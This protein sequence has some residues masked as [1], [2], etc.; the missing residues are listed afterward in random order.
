[1]I[2]ISKLVS[3]L[4]P[5]GIR[6]FFDLALGMRDVISLGV[7]EPDFPTPW[8]IRE[9]AIHYIEQG[10]TQYTSNKGLRELRLAITNRLRHEYELDYDPDN[11]ILIT[12]GVSEAFDLAIRTIINPGDEVIIP[13]PCY[14]A[15]GPVVTLAGGKP[16]F[17]PT[18]FNT[19][20]KLTPNEI[21]KSCTKKTKVIILGY[22]SNPTG[23]SY[24]K[25]EL[26]KL[27]MAIQKNNLIVISDELYSELTY[28]FKHTPW[29]TLKGAK[30]HCVYLNGFSKA[31]AMTGW[32]IGYAMGPKEIIDGMTKIHQYTMLSAPTM[33]QFA[34]LEA[35]QK[36][37]D[38]VIEMREEY[39]RRRNFVV[40]NLNQ[41]GLK[42]N[43]PQGAFYIFC[44]IESAG[45]DEIEFANRLLKQHKVAVVPGTAFG[46]SGKGYIRISYASSME[47]LKEAMNHIG[48]F[49]AKGGFKK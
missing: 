11:E 38:S 49:L 42:C 14:V 10:Y 41:M 1:M 9:T 46:T 27:K 19:G 36:G 48:K 4:A 12:V 45:L 21:D 37:Q 43:M 7:G 6:K 28:D 31:Y 33:G 8:D 35:I 44:S 30:S 2:E 18:K 47:N 25:T 13:E 24:T 20:F 3:E 17:I 40:K 15:Y 16:I 26:E 39:K 22:P 5:S 32:R 29:P 23:A 34:A